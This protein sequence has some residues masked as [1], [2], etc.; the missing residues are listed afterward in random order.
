MYNQVLDF[1]YPG[2]SNYKTF[3]AYFGKY[4]I[5]RVPGLFHGARY[6]TAWYHNGLSHANTHAAHT[7]L[8]LSIYLAFSASIML[9]MTFHLFVCLWFVSFHCDN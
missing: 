5:S 7:H 6:V 8:D 2:V 9:R 3:L 1:E 4:I